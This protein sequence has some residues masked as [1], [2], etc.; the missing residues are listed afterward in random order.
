MHTQQGRRFLHGAAFLINEG[1]SVG[2]LFRGEDRGRA[3]LHALGLG[4]LASAPDAV[5]DERPFKLGNAREH[6]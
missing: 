5:D 1:A 3:K 2:D 6:G 4:R